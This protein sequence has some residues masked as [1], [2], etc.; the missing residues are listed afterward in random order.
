MPITIRN[1][2]CLVGTASLDPNSVSVVVTSP[3]YNLG[4]AYKTYR[5]SL[6]E[7]DYLDFM[8]KWADITDRA[9]DDN[10]SVFLNIGYKPSD[11]CFPFRVIQSVTSNNRLRVQNVIHWIK[12]IAV[13]GNTVGHYKPIN[14]D[15]Y[16]NGCHE[17]IFHLTK[18]G[19]VLLDR[20]SVG[21][22]YK[23]KSNLTRGSRGKNGDLRCR[24]NVWLI[25]Y[26]TIQNRNKDR[27]HPATFPVR[28]PEMC[29]QLHG[30]S[31]TKLVL[32]PFA[33]IGTTALACKNL[34][35]DF[36]GFDIDENYCEIAINRL[37]TELG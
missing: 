21:V 7:Q 36:V 37:R 19:K 17:Y 13:N 34:G 18:T 3:P 10:G 20:T 14:S 30:L 32:D 26:E 6:P 22:A 27:P 16:L 11:P 28:L 8:S 35:V 9:L 12:S 25:P 2:D 29:I 5:D 31:R 1:E 33:G 4:T 23:H 24:G 15:R